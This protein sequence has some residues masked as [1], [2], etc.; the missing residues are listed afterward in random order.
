M[1]ND[2]PFGLKFKTS[3]VFVGDF[4]Y[5]EQLNP[6]NYFF[7]NEHFGVRTDG[8]YVNY[9]N[10]N[11]TIKG[12][13][14]LNKLFN[15]NLK[16]PSYT[17]FEKIK[18]IFRY[19]YLHDSYYRIIKFVPNIET[20]ELYLFYD[21]TQY[22]DLFMGLKGFLKDIQENERRQKN[23]LL[24]EHNDIVINHDTKISV[25]YCGRDMILKHLN[26]SEYGK[27][28][29]FKSKFIFLKTQHL[30]YDNK[31]VN[32]PHKWGRAEISST[33]YVDF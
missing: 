9:T 21:T 22:V 20:N 28:L 2:N 23:K 7:L 25:G 6:K 30:T 19:G 8:V 32:I 17:R 11:N 14:E 12:L 3:D 5:G 4:D 16:V 18:Q 24:F 10:E 31:V 13:T 27:E 33:K 29:V 1:V 15:L 26:K